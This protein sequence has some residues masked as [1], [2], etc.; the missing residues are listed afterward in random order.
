MFTPQGLLG[1]PT[2][3]HLDSVSLRFVVGGGP[4][5]LSSAFMWFLASLFST[6]GYESGSHSAPGQGHWVEVQ[7]QKRMSLWCSI[8]LS[9]DGGD[10]FSHH[11]QE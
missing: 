9:L 5:A 3:K 4:S 11:S 1:S 8:H 10:I 7:R 6:R 2:W